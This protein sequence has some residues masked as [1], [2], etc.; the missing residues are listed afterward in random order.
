MAQ[1]DRVAVKGAMPQKTCVNPADHQLSQ[2]GRK[3]SPDPTS[4]QPRLLCLETYVERFDSSLH[5]WGTTGPLCIGVKHGWFLIGSVD[6]GPLC[7]SPED[8]TDL[9]Q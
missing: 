2:A 6:N 7:L 4:D 9:Q 1:L 5:C 3:G 8:S